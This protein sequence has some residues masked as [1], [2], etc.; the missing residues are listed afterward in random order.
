MSADLGG[1]DLG[2]GR[3]CGVCSVGTDRSTGRSLSRQSV[4]AIRLRPLSPSA[5]TSTARGI[6][7]RTNSTV[8]PAHGM[9]LGAPSTTSKGVD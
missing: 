9:L 1:M 7:A 8:R 5:A 2:G 4:S 6:V 3:W